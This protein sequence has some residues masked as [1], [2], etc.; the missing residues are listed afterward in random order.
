MVGI[1][2]DVPTPMS[3]EWGQP[4]EMFDSVGVVL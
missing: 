3:M 1:L 2:R 4:W